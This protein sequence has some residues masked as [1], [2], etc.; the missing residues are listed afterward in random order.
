[1]LDPSCCWCGISHVTIFLFRNRM[2][3]VARGQ[4]AQRYEDGFRIRVLVLSYAQ[5]EKAD[6]RRP[7]PPP[8]P[9][10]TPCGTLLRLPTLFLLGARLLLQGFYLLLTLTSLTLPFFNPQPSC[11]LVQPANQ[12]GTLASTL[13]SILLRCGKRHRIQGAFLEIFLVCVL[14]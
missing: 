2:W 11:P 10:P 9:T 7:C 3:S 6:S 8:Q 14:Q 13:P 5:G 4:Q 12:S 1:M